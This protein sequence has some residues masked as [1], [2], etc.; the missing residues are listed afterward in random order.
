ML[1][2]VAPMNRSLIAAIILAAILIAAS[3]MIVHGIE[4][5]KTFLE[6]ANSFTPCNGAGSPPPCHN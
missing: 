1:L 6:I 2:S 5:F 3:P 4:S